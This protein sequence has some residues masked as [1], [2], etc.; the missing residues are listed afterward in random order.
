ML[1]FQIIQN[2]RKRETSWHVGDISPNKF[3]NEDKIVI[4]DCYADGHELE[5]IVKNF[6]N[7]P[8]P[9]Q[10]NKRSC[11]WRGTFAEFI[12]DNL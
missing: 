5:H 4:I 11:I 9:R 7:L 6:V 12:W 3:D 8:I 2:G 1:Y 10:E